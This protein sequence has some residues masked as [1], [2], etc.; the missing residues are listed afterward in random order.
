MNQSNYTNCH[1][2]N[3][4]CQ[5]N[6]CPG[7]DEFLTCELCGHT[8]IDVTRNYWYVGGKGNT[9]QTLCDDV[10]ACIRRKSNGIKRKN[11]EAKQ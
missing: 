3:Q 11:L 10:L 8:G 6:I 1:H 9:L 5:E 2:K 4:S 7:C